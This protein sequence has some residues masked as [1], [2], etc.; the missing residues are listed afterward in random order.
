[1]TIA[2]LI[3]LSSAGTTIWRHFPTGVL[4]YGLRSA[5]LATGSA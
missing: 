4:P 1:M 2:Q 3:H 5:A